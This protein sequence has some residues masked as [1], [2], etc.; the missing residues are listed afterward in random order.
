MI[1]P[2]CSS[3]HTAKNGLRVRKNGVN[4]EW[5]CRNCG[6]YYTTGQ[7]ESRIKEYA[8]ILLVDIETSPFRVWVWHLGKQ[9][10]SHNS[11]FKKNGKMENW[12]VMS[13]AAKW[14]FDPEVMSDV[15][16]PT[17]AKNRDDKRILD[18]I[19]MM[20]DKADIVIAHN[21]DRFDIRKLNA[22]FIDNGI[23]PPSPFRTVDTLKVSRREFAFV[24]HKQDFLTKKFELEQKLSTE[25]SLWTDGML[26]IPERLKEMEEYNRHDVMGLEGVYLKYRPYIKNHP[27]IGVLM[28]EDVCPNCGSEHLDETDSVYFTT[29]NKFP[30]FRCNNCHTPYIRHKKNSNMVQT[31]LRSVPK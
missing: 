5:I 22:R 20:L 8:K 15:V 17:E 12:F 3:G 10:I 7:D 24:S 1:C 11:I 4:Q 30:V 19:W 29:A 21:G 14:L 28:D 13:W 31:N 9:R 16:T 25:F 27:N 18:S 6:K 26:G 2:H 23:M